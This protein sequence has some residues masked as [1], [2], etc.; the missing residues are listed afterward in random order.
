M[1]QH[2]KKLLKIETFVREINEKG[3]TAL[4]CAARIKKSNG[5]FPE[6][7]RMIIKLL[8]ENGSD[9]FIQTHEVRIMLP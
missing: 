4:H 6:E 2:L 5:H 7:D 1:K 8:M 9:V 3:E